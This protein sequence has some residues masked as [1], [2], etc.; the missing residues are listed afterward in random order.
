MILKKLILY[1][2]KQNTTKKWPKNEKSISFNFSVV[3]GLYVLYSF[4][5][6]S[7]L[8]RKSNPVKIFPIYA[9]HSAEASDRGVHESEKAGV[10]EVWERRT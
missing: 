8:S 4:K 6:F 7:I 2:G 3:E 10:H 9:T 1:S 5:Q